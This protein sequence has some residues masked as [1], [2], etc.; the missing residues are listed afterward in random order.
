[1]LHKT[2]NWQKG[3]FLDIC[4]FIFKCLNHAQPC[5]KVLRRRGC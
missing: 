3:N 1:M 2:L 4:L 5:F